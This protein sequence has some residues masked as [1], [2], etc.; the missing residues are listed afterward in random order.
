MTEAAIRHNERTRIVR[1]LDA[2]EDPAGKS[3][4]SAWLDAMEDA[5]CAVIARD[6]E[7]AQ[8]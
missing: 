4:E 3:D 7:A 5:S 1:M 2:M 6:I 8:R